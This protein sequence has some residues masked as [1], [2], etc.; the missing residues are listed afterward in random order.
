VTGLTASAL[1]GF[2]PMIG[3]KGRNMAVSRW[4]LSGFERI[5]FRTAL[6]LAGLLIA[7]RI[8]AVAILTFL[9]HSR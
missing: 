7:V 9:H 6:V 8:G 3:V 1:I 5:L 2:Y 4:Q